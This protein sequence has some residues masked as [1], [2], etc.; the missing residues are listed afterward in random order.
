LAIDALAIHRLAAPIHGDLD[1]RPQV[2][3]RILAPVEIDHQPSLRQV[4]ANHGDGSRRVRLL[5]DLDVQGHGQRCAPNG[6]HHQHGQCQEGPAGTRPRPKGPQHPCAGVLDVLRV[7]HAPGNAKEQDVPHG[8]RRQDQR[9][10]IER[11][12]QRVTGASAAHHRPGAQGHQRRNKHGIVAKGG[13]R[14]PLDDLG[15]SNGRGL[16]QKAPQAKTVGV[17]QRTRQRQQRGS[18][19]RSEWGGQQGAQAAGAAIPSRPLDQ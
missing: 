13:Q 10:R 7:E 11:Q 2:P 3:Q 6:Q 15:A 8:E 16:E 9:D 12:E 14:L 5:W 19:Q 17:H 4:L 1:L 18:R